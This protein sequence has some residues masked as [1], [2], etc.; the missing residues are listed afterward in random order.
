MIKKKA[1]LKEF[2]KILQDEDVPA[3]NRNI[4]ITWA[5]FDVSYKFLTPRE[6]ADECIDYMYGGKGTI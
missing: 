4:M 3:Y 2:R 5:L 1:W 6:S